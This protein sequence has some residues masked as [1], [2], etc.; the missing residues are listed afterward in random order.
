MRRSEARGGLYASSEGAPPPPPPPPTA[1]PT[2]R[3]RPARP[4]KPD[5]RP[6]ASPVQTGPPDAQGPRRSGPQPRRSGHPSVPHR[7]VPGVG[8]GPS[9]I[10]GPLQGRHVRR[11]DAPPRARAAGPTGPG[12]DADGPPTAE[13]GPGDERGEGGGGERGG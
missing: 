12:L 3:S 2:L 13:D 1:P 11:R 7:L 9:E 10:V 6:L 8:D 5:R 4:A